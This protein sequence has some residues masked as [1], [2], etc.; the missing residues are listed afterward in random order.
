MFLHSNKNYKN[1]LFLGVAQ[2]QVQGG[3]VPRP[4][5]NQGPAPI[6]IQRAYA[7]LGLP[8]GSAPGMRPMAPQQ[9]PPSNTPPPQ[10]SKFGCC[11]FLTATKNTY[12][13]E[14]RNLK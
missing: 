13:T 9:A 2:A 3:P 10:P 8:A 12:I 5:G 7:A 4:Q 14:S 1:L 6:D 11:Q